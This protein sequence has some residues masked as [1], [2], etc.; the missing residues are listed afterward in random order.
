MK[1]IILAYHPHYINVKDLEELMNELR[2]ENEGLR[3]YV[4]THLKDDVEPIYTVQF[5]DTER[6]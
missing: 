6:K 2:E 5:A 1:F 3:V 4:I